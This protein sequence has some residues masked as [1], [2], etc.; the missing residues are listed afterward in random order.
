MI[1]G[2]LK[3]GGL[4]FNNEPLINYFSYRNVLQNG[5]NALFKKKTRVF[6]KNIIILYILD[7]YDLVHVL[8]ACG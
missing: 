3:D 2:A 8:P 6:V 7:H 5:A 4:K 1:F